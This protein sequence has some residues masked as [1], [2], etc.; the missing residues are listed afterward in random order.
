MSDS[1]TGDLTH[2]HVVLWLMNMWCSDSWTGGALT[3]NQ[4]YVHCVR[5]SVAIN[6][7]RREQGDPNNEIYEFI[8]ECNVNNYHNIT[9]GTNT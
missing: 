5:Y 2:E 9:L 7:H 1:W 4:A 8:R 3:H 6:V